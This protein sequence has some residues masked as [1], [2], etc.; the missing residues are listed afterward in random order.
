MQIYHNEILYFSFKI[1]IKQKK[2]NTIGL[3]EICTMEIGL[4][5][6]ELETE[7]LRPL[8]AKNMKEN[9]K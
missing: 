1:L 2:V 8:V 3:M 5:I 9:S 4:M 6:I 7:F